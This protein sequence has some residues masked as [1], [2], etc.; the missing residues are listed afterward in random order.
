VRYRRWNR[1]CAIKWAM[2]GGKGD[3]GAASGA[4]EGTTVVQRVV[5]EVS[6][7]T[8]FPVLT[9]NNY[10]DWAMLMRV[11]LKARGLWVAVDKGGVDPQEDM[12]ALDVLV[13]AVPPE[14]VATVADKSSA[15][16]AW[17]AIAMMR[18]DNERVKKAAAQQLRNQFDRATFKEGET[19][20]DFALWM[21]SMVA[22]LATMGEIVEERKVVEKILH[23]IPQRLRQIAL[24][25]TTLLDVQYLI[26]ANLAGR[27]KAAEEAFEEPPSS[28]QHEGKLYLTE[29][30]WDARR[31][32]R[33]VENPGSGGS[34]SS[35]GRAGAE[36][37]GER[38]RGRG[39][40]GHGPQKN[41]DCRRCGKLSHW[42]RKCRSKS[43]EQAHAVHDEEVALMVAM[44]T[45]DLIS[46][47][48]EKPAAATS[49]VMKGPVVIHEEKVFAQ[50]GRP[51]SSRNAKLWILD[52]G[53]TNHMTGSRAVFVIL[54]TSVRG[55]VRFRDDSSVE[56]EGRGKVEFVCNNGESKTFEGVYFIPK[57]T[58]N[59]ISVGRLDEDGYQISI[60]G[61]ELAIREPDGRLLAKVKRSDS[62]L[63]LLIVELSTATCLVPRGEAEA[64]RWHERLGHLNFPA[65]KKLA[66]EDLV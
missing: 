48:G 28:M 57:L 7:A 45:V 42:A 63:Y 41:D 34:D 12:M 65:M 43:K 33:D 26:V 5:R 40:G 17:D 13:L 24:T 39:S 9:K 62:R 3:D 19:V 60:S 1:D 59:I 52:T 58:A 36:R 53:A 15:K 55:T 31:A 38:G 35:A 46:V 61:G 6:G 22:T 20:E 47:K 4:K 11:K 18:V 23:Y 2:A 32:R 8:A 27:L 44:V 54:D 25:I 66:R 29:E 16:E 50:L 37:S 49:G 30:E 21:N 64:W 56:I 10:S 14:V 51:E